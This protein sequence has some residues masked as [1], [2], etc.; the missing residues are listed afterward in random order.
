MELN[1]KQEGHGRVHEESLT[2]SQGDAGQFNSN[3]KGA[4]CVSYLQESSLQLSQVDQNPNINFDNPEG[5]T[6]QAP[7]Y[8]NLGH[9]KNYK[10]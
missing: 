8:L 9:N 1:E 4:T 6:R 2:L 5:S 3:H 10:T 7:Q